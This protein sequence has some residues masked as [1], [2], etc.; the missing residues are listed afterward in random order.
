MATSVEKRPPPHKHEPAPEPP[1]DPVPPELPPYEPAPGAPEEPPPPASS[2][3][4][5][6]TA[7]AA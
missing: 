2:R 4:L 7:R 6:P 5:K 3:A 1:L